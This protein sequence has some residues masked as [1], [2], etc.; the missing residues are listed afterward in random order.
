MDACEVAQLCLHN[1][2]IT[3]VVIRYRTGEQHEEEMPADLVV[4][5]SGRGSRA[6]MARLVRVWE[7]AGNQR[8]K[9]YWIRHAHLSLPRTP[10]V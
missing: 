2:R 7:S 10:S 1:E 8:Q 9:R 4:D 5:T 6:A 3:G